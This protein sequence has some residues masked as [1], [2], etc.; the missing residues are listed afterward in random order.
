MYLIPQNKLENI[1]KWDLIVK[2]LWQI[3][4]ENF[5]LIVCVKISKTKMTLFKYF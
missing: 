4:F 2:E 3:E 5:W 1:P